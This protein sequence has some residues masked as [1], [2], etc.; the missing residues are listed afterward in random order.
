M[1]KRQIRDGVIVRDTGLKTNYKT[2]IFEII[3]SDVQWA[4][5]GDCLISNISADG[6]SLGMV[7]KLPPPLT[8]PLINKLIKRIQEEP[9]FKEVLLKTLV[10]AC[11]A[12]STTKDIERDLALMKKYFPVDWIIQLEK[13]PLS[14]LVK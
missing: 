9:A 3:K 7:K 14:S 4:T 10:D 1:Y 12:S 11:A 8:D 5:V 2:P 13:M 6:N